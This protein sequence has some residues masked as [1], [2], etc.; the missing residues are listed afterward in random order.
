[1]YQMYQVYH[2]QAC[3]SPSTAARPYPYLIISSTP[4]IARAHSKEWGVLLIPFPQLSPPVT[5]PS[6]ER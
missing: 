3:E 1:M 4:C 2:A 6:T 5:C